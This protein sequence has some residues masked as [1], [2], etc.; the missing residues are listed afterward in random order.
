[1]PVYIRDRKFHNFVCE[2]ILDPSYLQFFSSI[3]ASTIRSAW[4]QT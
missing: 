2:F 4:H 3:L 1:M